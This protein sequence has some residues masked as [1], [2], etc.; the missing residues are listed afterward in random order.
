M[1][2]I[3]PEDNYTC[4]TGNK[5]PFPTLKWPKPLALMLGKDKVDQRGRKNAKFSASLN[6]HG[7][8][9]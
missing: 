2:T 8:S 4:W 9:V 5:P 1:N 7:L 6:T 3:N